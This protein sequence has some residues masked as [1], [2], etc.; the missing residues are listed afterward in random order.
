MRKRVSNPSS[1]HRSQNR[2]SEDHL[3]LKGLSFYPQLPNRS[4]FVPTAIKG[5]SWGSSVTGLESTAKSWAPPKSSISS[6][7][8][9]AIVNT[10]S[11]LLSRW[12]YAGTEHGNNTVCP[13]QPLRRK[14]ISQCHSSSRLVYPDFLLWMSLDEMLPR[15]SPEPRFYDL[16]ESWHSITLKPSE[17]CTMTDY[18]HFLKIMLNNEVQTGKDWL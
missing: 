4:N 9:L 16:M 13:Q 7:P 3:S 6:L 2:G 1:P 18:N 11:S 12:I 8:A 14:K 5:S 17:P 10:P 15:V